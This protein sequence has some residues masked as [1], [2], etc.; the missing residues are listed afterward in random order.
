MKNIK[1][2]PLSI[3]D[4]TDPEIQPLLRAMLA[5]NSAKHIGVNE[6]CS[7]PLISAPDRAPDIPPVP[8]L[9]LCDDDFT[10]IQ[11]DIG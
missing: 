4:G 5:V 6:L 1:R 7:R 2:R 11:A 9:K 3:P 8:T 10:E